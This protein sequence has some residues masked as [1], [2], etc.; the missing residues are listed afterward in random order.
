LRHDAEAEFARRAAL[1]AGLTSATLHAV[2]QAD[3]ADMTSEFGGRAATVARNLRSR[4]GPSDVMAAV[5]S[6]DGD[7]LGVWPR[8]GRALAESSMDTEDVQ[9]GIRLGGAV[10]DLIFWNHRAQPIVRLSTTFNSPTGVRM[11]VHVGSAYALSLASAYLASAPAVQGGWAYV[12]DGRGRVLATTEAAL[13]G[14]SAPGA[15][16][17]VG[18]QASF[19]REPRTLVLRR[20]PG[21]QRYPLACRSRGASLALIAAG[22]KALNTSTQLVAAEERERTAQRLAH[23]RLHDALTGLPNRAPFLDRTEHALSRALGVQLAIDD[24]G[25]GQSSLEQLV[26]SLPV[27]VLKLDRSFVAEMD[28]T[29]ERAVVAAVG[30]RGICSAAPSMRRH[31]SRPSTRAGPMPMRCARRRERERPLATSPRPAPERACAAVWPRT[32]R[33]TA[34]R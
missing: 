3:P 1:T 11:F 29:R 33:A 20:G 12:F 32:D 17:V 8:R 31:S 23:E 10:S 6:T 27:D 4:V 26:R 30:P 34:V 28:Q 7:V 14:K 16:P 9:P 5:L 15:R 24:F 22:V 19:E 25:I 13:Q 18:D 2:F 21:R